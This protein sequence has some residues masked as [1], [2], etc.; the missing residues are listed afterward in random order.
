MQQTISLSGIVIKSTR[1]I[2]LILEAFKQTPFSVSFMGVKEEGTFF[3]EVELSK[4]IAVSGLLDEKI[5]ENIAESLAENIADLL[6]ENFKIYA[7][8][9]MK[10]NSLIGATLPFLK[11]EERVTEQELSMD[12][13]F[14]KHTSIRSAIDYWTALS[15]KKQHFKHPSFPFHDE[16]GEPVSLNFESVC[17]VMKSLNDDGLKLFVVPK[18]KIILF[19]VIQT[20]GYTYLAVSTSGILSVTPNIMMN[21]ENKG[22]GYLYGAYPEEKLK[23]CIIALNDYWRSNECVT[24]KLLEEAD[25]FDEV[26]VEDEA[27]TDENEVEDEEE[28]EE[29]KPEII[30]FEKI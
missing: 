13:S 2:E 24:R 30:D 8:F 21:L 14:H 1:Q 27:K 7:R 23:E 15:L 25:F 19:G 18:A 5:K 17:K 29:N 9:S 12:E 6:E 3:E 20:W 28:T 26:E 16:E 11:E 4:T 10:N 22:D